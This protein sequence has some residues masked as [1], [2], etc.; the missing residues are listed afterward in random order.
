[1]ANNFPSR[2]ALG[3]RARREHERQGIPSPPRFSGMCRFMFDVP[4]AILTSILATVD[5]PTER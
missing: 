5:G 2:R 3:Q 4:S 1:M